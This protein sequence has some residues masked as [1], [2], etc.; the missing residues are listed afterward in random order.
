M[1]NAQSVNVCRKGSHSEHVDVCLA[2]IGTVDSKMFAK[3]SISF[4]KYF[5][6]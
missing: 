5:E 4:S 2:R 3:N 1:M 6:I